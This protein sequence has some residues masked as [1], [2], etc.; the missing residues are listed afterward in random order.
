MTGC[1]TAVH[2][3]YAYTHLLITV[4]CWPLIVGLSKL[5]NTIKKS[6]AHNNKTQKYTP[7]SHITQTG[8]FIRLP[9]GVDGTLNRL[10]MILLRKKKS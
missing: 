9:S 1:T 2:M 4:N 8:I 7:V 6:L 5:S 10:R 3:C